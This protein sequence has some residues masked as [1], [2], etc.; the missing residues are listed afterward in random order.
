MPV[1]NPILQS[2]EPPVDGPCDWIVDVTC[3]PNW[4]DYSP[5][6]QS[7][8]QEWARCL[9]GH[10]AAVRSEVSGPRRLPHVAG[11]GVGQ[12]RGHA[13]DDPLD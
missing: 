11:A 13:L 9:S 1:I 3:V 12:W 10:G 2:G 4:A 6:V 5:I 7:T 8:A